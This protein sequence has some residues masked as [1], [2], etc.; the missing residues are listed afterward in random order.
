ME[1][2]KIRGKSDAVVVPL[3]AREQYCAKLAAM[4][5]EVYGISRSE[6]NGIVDSITGAYGLLRKNSEMMAAALTL[7]YTTNNEIDYDNFSTFYEE[8][9]GS[10]RKKTTVE[11]E[12]YMYTLYRYVKYC[13]LYYVG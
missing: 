5:T 12:K 10:I 9:I 1:I 6:S 3:S 13:N 2:A 11:S 4:I 7:I 8:N